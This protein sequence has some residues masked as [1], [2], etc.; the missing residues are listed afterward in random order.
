MWRSKTEPSWSGRPAG[1]A[2]PGGGKKNS[3]LKMVQI[4][5]ISFIKIGMERSFSA[6]AW[7]GGHDG[8]AKGVWG[9]AGGGSKIMKMF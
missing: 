1:G 3:F 8:E 9:E 2:W 6:S 5:I 7:S 4:D